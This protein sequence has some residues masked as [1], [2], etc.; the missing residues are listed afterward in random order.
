VLVGSSPLARPAHPLE[1][2]GAG[3]GDNDDDGGDDDGGGC[4]DGPRQP[5]T[6][7]TPT[8]DAPAAVPAA[9]FADAS[10]WTNPVLRFAG[11]QPE[12]VP[13]LLALLV[14]RQVGAVDLARCVEPLT[15]AA[16]ASAG[17]VEAAGAKTALVRAACEPSLGEGAGERGDREGGRP[18]SGGGDE[19]PLSLAAG[20]EDLVGAVAAAVA[21][22]EAEVGGSVRESRPRRPKRGQ[23][24]SNDAPWKRIKAPCLS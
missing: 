2:G 24:P 10:T 14:A 21:A 4:E 11:V 9:V 22:L 8:A 12:F 7:T 20:S 13:R 23:G 15:T 19:A 3:G 6:L 5:P 16:G 1:N 18:G 17:A